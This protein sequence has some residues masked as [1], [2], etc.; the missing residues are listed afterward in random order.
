M[1]R[2]QDPPETEK[3]EAGRELDELAREGARRMLVTALEA[4]VAEYIERHRGERDADGRAAVVRNGKSRKR[5]VTLGCGTVEVEAP[6]VNDKRVVDG[7]RARFTSEVL[8]PYMRR[9]PK[10]DEVLPV[11]YLRG[12]STGDFEPALKSLLGDKAAGLSSTSITRMTTAW[13]SE[14]EAFRKQDLSQ[15]EY[16]Y[17]WVDGVHFNIRLEDDR[18]CT[19]VV[20]GV[21]K[22]GKK[23]VL[24]V[25]DGYRESKESWLLT[26]RSLVKRGLRAPLLATGDGALGFWAAAREVW[27]EMK[28]QLCW[29]HKLKNM[30][31]KLPRRLQGRAKRAL[32]EIMNAETR[33]QA[34]EA[35]EQ[36][37]T[38]FGAKYPRA[39]AS[40]IDNQKRLL[41][42]FDIPAQHWEH[43]R[44]ANPIESA[45]ATVRLRQRVTK[46]AGS[47]SKALWMAFKLLD[48]AS[49][50]WRRINSPELVA[51]LL[52]GEKF[53]DGLPESNN[54]GNAA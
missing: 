21:R 42:F 32:N 8:P 12:L 45:F 41:T 30:L 47:R 44:S 52:L 39:V 16:A 53:V 54:V 3:V 37:Q 43:M 27:P 24:A 35:C 34:E 28:H 22:D 38:D 23:R 2:I 51:R 19:L 31:D 36:F 5:R 46:G 50:R 4:E 29:V 25:E 11:L 1:L 49:L 13:K 7:E 40:L 18:L 48:M 15:E 20:I 9:S 10:V 33:E 17:I 14:Y 6:R 26:L